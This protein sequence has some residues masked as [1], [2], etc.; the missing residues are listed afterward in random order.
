LD[1]CDFHFFGSVWIRTPLVHTSIAK[2]KTKHKFH[3]NS[4]K[5]EKT[6]RNWM[7]NKEKRN[8]HEEI[9]VKIEERNCI[10]N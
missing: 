9:E 5:K 6:K 10:N 3:Y 2:N 8:Y 1:L 4:K 7:V